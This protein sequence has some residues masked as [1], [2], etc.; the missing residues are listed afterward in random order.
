MATQRSASKHSAET[1][2]QSTERE[3]AIETM[4]PRNVPTIPE[5]SL[6]SSSRNSH[7]QRSSATRG[8]RGDRTASGHHADGVFSSLAESHQDYQWRQYAPKGAVKFLHWLVTGHSE[9]APSDQE[10]EGK[11]RNLA[12]T[13]G[14]LREYQARLGMPDGGSRKEQEWV[15]KELCKRLFSSGVPI[16]VLQPVV[17]IGAQGLTG[18]RGFG[19]FLLPAGG[20]LIPPQDTVGYSTHFFEMHRSFCMYQLN[21]YEKVLARLASFA[22]NTRTINSVKDDIL[23]KLLIKDECQFEQQD[24]ETLRNEEV[25]ATEI[26][27]LASKGYGLFFLTSVE[28]FLT[29]QGEEI[30]LNEDD[31]TGGPIFDGDTSVLSYHS[32]WSVDDSI[33]E[34]FTRLAT[35]EAAECLDAIDRLP[36]VDE[37]W[38]RH[39]VV[40]FRALSSAGSSGLWFNGSWQDM[41]LAGGLAAVVALVFQTNTKFWKN[42]RMIFEVIASFVVGLVGGLIAIALPVSTCFTAIAVA[43]MID[44]LRGFGIVFSIMGMCCFCTDFSRDIKDASFFSSISCFS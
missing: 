29:E 7:S 35:I 32:F 5:A 24:V 1:R 4:A 18:F 12:R 34:L 40:L 21:L 11:I 28:K 6:L 3:Q 33:R 26:L 13:I 42:Q 31:E 36:G 39:Y 10:N 30:L 23:P 43:S 37:V 16:W 38:P 27:D 44:S 8:S 9:A 22:T 41:L 19:F 15:L 14:L 17:G 2:E 20:I 25:V